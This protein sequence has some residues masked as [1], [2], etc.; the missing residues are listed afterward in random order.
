[1]AGPPPPEPLPTPTQKAV[2]PVKSPEMPFSSI[3]T[4]MKL[5]L[6]LLFPLIFYPQPWTIETLIHYVSTVLGILECWRDS[7]DITSL[8]NTAIVV[9]GLACI[10]FMLFADRAFNK[11][12]PHHLSEDPTGPNTTNT[13]VQKSE[14]QSSNF[15]AARPRTGSKTSKSLAQSS[16]FAG[17][18]IIWMGFFLSAVVSAVMTV[19]STLAACMGVHVVWDA[20]GEFEHYKLSASLACLHDPKNADKHAKLLLILNTGKNLDHAWWV[21]DHVL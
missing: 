8:T 14:L 20:A 18:P 10:Q 3:Y 21:I 17:N 12:N 5:L 7:V 15:R 19:V 16:Q 13:R 1:M 6:F 4:A 2:L 11:T 9:A